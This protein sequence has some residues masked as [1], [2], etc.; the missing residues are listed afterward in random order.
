MKQ[1]V[2]RHEKKRTE[3]SDKIPIRRTLRNR[4]VELED[5][6]GDDWFDG[7]LENLVLRVNKVGSEHFKKNGWRRS[8]YSA[9]ITLKTDDRSLA[10]MSGNAR[11]HL[12]PQ[13]RFEVTNQ[14]LEEMLR[15]EGLVDDG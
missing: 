15:E 2:L 12:T 5:Q 11:K 7:F 9:N 8:D 10:V 13:G 3:Y 1:K 6:K 14:V 4:L